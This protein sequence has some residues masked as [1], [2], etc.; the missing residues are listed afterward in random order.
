MESQ[1]DY[2]AYCDLWDKAL[3]SG[4]FDAPKPKEILPIGEEDSYDDVDEYSKAED[5]LQ[6]S[7]PYYAYRQY[8][9]NEEKANQ[10][11][12]LTE[13]K[14]A[15][16][17]YP[18]SQGKD[19]ENPSTSWVNNDNF[20][21]LNDLKTKLYDLECKL[22]TEFGGGKKWTEKCHHPED[23]KFQKQIESLK[24]KIDE[25]SNSLGTED[26]PTRSIYDVDKK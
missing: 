9:I 3:A 4:E 7:D 24:E 23:K 15:L 16:P 20:Q 2:E 26:E 10:G 12:Q 13:G 22:N 8:Q 19:S 6:E 18:D 21:K 14:S 11:K 5:L 25:L 1:A 17:V